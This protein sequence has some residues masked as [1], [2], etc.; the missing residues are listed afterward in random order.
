MILVTGSTGLVGSHLIYDLLRKGYQVKALV[1]KSS[2]KDKI[3]HTFKLYSPEAESLFDK[4][5]WAE[6]DV[7]DIVSLEEALVDVQQVYHTAAMV[8]FNPRDKK[9]IYRINVDG[10]S[11]IV[12]LCLER[13][14]LKLCFVSS[15]AAVGMTEDGLPITE[16]ASWKPTKNMSA[17]SI[18]KYRA[19]MEI[20]RGITEGL[21]AV[22]VN[23]SVVLGPGSWKTSSASVFPLIDRGLQYYTHGITGYVDVKDVAKAMIMLMESKIAGERFIL[24]SENLSYKTF[25]EMVANSLHVKPP[26]TYLTPLIS[27]IAWRLE[28]LRSRLLFDVPRITRNTM[29]IAHKTLIY[30]SAKIQSQLNIELKKI[31]PVVGELANYYQMAKKTSHTN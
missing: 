11:N 2:N 22:I 30:S 5:T 24:S 10:T 25:F 9:E 19:E 21:N 6:G 12:N 1:R 23:P 20:W 7:T 16:D 31:E 8:S 4:I 29:E 27:G 3:L 28:Y 18:S 15:I 17:Y 13:N 14:I 26:Q